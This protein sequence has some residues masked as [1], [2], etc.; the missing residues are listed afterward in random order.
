[1]V[2][3]GAGEDGEHVSTREYSKKRKKPQGVASGLRFACKP[4]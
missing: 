4:A 1:M 2:A 3:E